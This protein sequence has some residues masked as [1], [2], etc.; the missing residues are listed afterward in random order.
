MFRLSMH[1]TVQPLQAEASEHDMNDFIQLN[2]VIEQFVFACRIHT[3]F[4]LCCRKC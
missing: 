3:M 4:N 2:A 1:G